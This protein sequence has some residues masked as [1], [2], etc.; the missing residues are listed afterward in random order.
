MDEIVVDLGGVSTELEA[1]PPGMY[2]ATVSDMSKFLSKA[3]NQ[4]TVKWEFTVQEPEEAAGRKLFYNTSLQRH[5][6]F[7]FKRLLRELGF[8]EDALETEIRLTKADVE[9]MDCVLVV[10][11]DVYDERTRNKV[12][13]VL[14]PDTPLEQPDDSDDIDVDEIPF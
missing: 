8:D 4:P 14:S 5:A 12:V 1:L 2:L 9:G 7:S 3:S 11:T 13:Q 10:E 6:L